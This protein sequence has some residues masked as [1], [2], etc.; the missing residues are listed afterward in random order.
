MEY[1]LWNFHGRFW[2]GGNNSF[3]PSES[4]SKNFYT[5]VNSDL[6]SPT[7]HI[8]T[9]VNDESTNLY[10]NTS[11]TQG[12]TS[13]RTNLEFLT[14]KNGVPQNNRISS[15]VIP[16]NQDDLLHSVSLETVQITSDLVSEQSSMDSLTPTDSSLPPLL[17]HHTNSSL[18]NNDS[19]NI[20]NISS[21]NNNNNNSNN[22]NCSSNNSENNK[23]TRNSN[24]NDN[25]DEPCMEN[26]ENPS[27][28]NKKMVGKIEN[29]DNQEV[30]EGTDGTNIKLENNSA[31]DYLFQQREP[32]TSDEE[33]EEEE[34]D[35]D[36][37][38]I[39]CD[40]TVSQFRIIDSLQT[41]V[42]IQN[43][44]KSGEKNDVDT[45]ITRNVTPESYKLNGKR[46]TGPL[47]PQRIRYEREEYRCQICAY[48]CTV[49]KAFHKHLKT[50]T[51]GRETNQVKI[52]CVICGKD[53]SSEVDM[54]KHMKKHRDDRYFCCDICIFK[55]V[56]LKKLI[57]HRRMHTGEKPHLCPH[58]SYRSARRDN[59]RSHVRRVHKK[60]NLFCD[61]FSPRGLT[62]T[63]YV[64]N[65]T[66][67]ISSIIVPSGNSKESPLMNE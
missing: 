21:N 59:L 35:D 37:D 60:D 19:H 7:F 56:Q 17:N 22:S 44:F 4:I 63:D 40:E 14:V 6:E 64:S 48:S 46:K 47:T 13:L 9:P 16:E 49:E 36:D 52:S 25:N 57:Q 62:L 38:G 15:L 50:H 1:G 26:N 20:S 18:A 39:E 24:I 30:W 2:A 23:S 54:N 5:T 61:T 28:L 34:D 45:D 8:T 42:N 32:G 12:P 31:V 29:L 41:N 67:G 3:T 27:D 65:P 55:T 10:S 66:G 51:T 53:R 43:R 11:V 58:C 33:E